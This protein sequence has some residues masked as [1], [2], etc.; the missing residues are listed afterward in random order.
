MALR[1]HDVE[2]H[3]SLAGIPVC[4]YSHTAL[5][6]GHFALVLRNLHLTRWILLAEAAIFAPQVS[7]DRKQGPHG[8]MGFPSTRNN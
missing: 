8:S 3:V 1:I 6:A 7:R 4:L 5:D 2:R